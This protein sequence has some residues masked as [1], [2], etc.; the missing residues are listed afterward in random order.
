LVTYSNQAKHD[1][2]GVPL[3]LIESV[4]AVSAEVAEAMARGARERLGADVGVGITGIAGPG[5]ATPGKP[6][7]L[8]HLCAVLGESVL[9]QRIHVPGSRADVRTRSVIVAMHMLRELLG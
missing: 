8:V 5:G 1:L 7:G 6:V 2:A 3:E 9:A 4:G